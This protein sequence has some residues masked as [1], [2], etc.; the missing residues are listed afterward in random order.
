MHSLSI[1]ETHVVPIG[2]VFIV[3]T[4]GYVAIAISM[5]LILACIM[6]AGP[7]SLVLAYESGLIEALKRA[8]SE[9]DKSE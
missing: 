2:T 8:I 9:T 3:A 1:S 4:L 5:P 7:L 6:L